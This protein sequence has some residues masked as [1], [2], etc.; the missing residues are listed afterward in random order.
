MMRI[1]QNLRIG[2]KLAIASVLSILLVGAMIYSQMAGN[3]AVRS[4]S[5]EAATQQMIALNA[6]DA[7]ASIRGVQI[8]IRDIR[9]AGTAAALQTANDYSAARFKSV[10]GFADEMLKLSHSA[11][12]RARI[13]KLKALAGD[14]AKGAQQIVSV[15]SEAIL[16]EASRPSGGQLALKPLQRARNSTTRLFASPAR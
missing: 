9:L 12:N 8:G 14:Y 13:E 5:Q 1:I 7:K 16:V 10:H 6:I 2:T 11:E 4:S 3:A 15:R